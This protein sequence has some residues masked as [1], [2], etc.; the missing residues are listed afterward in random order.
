MTRLY[1][2]SLTLLLLL[3]LDFVNKNPHYNNYYYT[4]M[5]CVC[6]THSTNL[7]F[8]KAFDSVPHY[9]L[10]KKLWHMGINNNLQSS[11]QSYL[12]NRFQKVTINHCLSDPLPVKSGVPQGSILGPLFFILYI[13]GL[14]TTSKHSNIL[15]F[16]DDTKCYKKYIIH[17]TR[18]RYSQSKI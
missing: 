3:S 14:P 4:S 6:Q 17:L 7:D 9:I 16:A 18:R 12:T 13:N 5:N 8:S 10:L 11:F 2:L 1:K 15:N